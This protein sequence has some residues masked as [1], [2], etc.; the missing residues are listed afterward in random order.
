[1]E[2]RM[3]SVN[4]KEIAEIVEGSFVIKRSQDMLDVMAGVPSNKII[5]Y[6]GNLD[7]IFFDLKTGLAGE[8]LQKASNYSIQLG[9]VGDFSHYTSKSLHDFIYECNKGNQI[10][11]AATLEEILQRFGR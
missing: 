7:E 8:I 2:Y 5:L 3:H 9:I 4:G 1:M 6:R 11:F 10:V